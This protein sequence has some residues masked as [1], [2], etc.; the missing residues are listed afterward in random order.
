[1][2][3][4]GNEEPESLAERE[5]DDQRAGT[6]RRHRDRDQPFTTAPIGNDSAPHASHAAD[7]DRAKGDQCGERVSAPAGGLASS[8]CAHRD[9]RRD[10]RPGAVQLEHV[11]E[12]T[13]GRQTK[14]ALPDNRRDQSPR[15]APGRK[16]EWTVPIKH[17]H[18]KPC[19]GRPRTRREDDGPN[20]R[21][22]QRVD[23]IWSGLSHRQRADN[24]AHGESAAR[25]EPRR[26]HLHGRRIYAGKRE[27]SQQA[28]REDSAIAW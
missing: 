8:G 13:S 27:T 19:Y 17:E 2:E 16:G 26:D 20:P 24:G 1:H 5:A 9:K 15:E 18:E 25:A 14:T 12:I 4:D 11:P 6:A 3:R 23:E 21:S 22:R 28:T 7:R 10:P